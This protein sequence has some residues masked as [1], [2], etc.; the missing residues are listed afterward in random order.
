MGKQTNFIDTKAILCFING[1]CINEII[2]FA[3]DLMVGF[4]FNK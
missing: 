4:I 3:I 2:I 1:C